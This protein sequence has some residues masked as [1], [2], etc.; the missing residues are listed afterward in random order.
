V[1]A[2][3][4]ALGRKAYWET[5]SPSPDLV[6]M[7]LPGEMLYSAALQSDASLIEAGANEKVLLAGPTMLIGLLRAIA[8]G[9]REEALALNAQ[10]VAELGRALFERIA[11]LAEHWSDVGDKLEKSVAAYNKS[12]GSLE[13]RVLVTARKF[14][15]LE[16]APKD[17]EI[18]SPQPIDAL[19]RKLQAVELVRKPDLV[20]APD[21]ACESAQ[22]A[23]LQVQPRPRGLAAGGAPASVT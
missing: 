4:T 2:H 18:V 12:V 7:F 13:G 11:T 19:P 10:E 16:A 23:A 22:H 9:W 14:V 8:L 6:V 21:S 17:G 1:R 15:E 3:L 20:R 5:F